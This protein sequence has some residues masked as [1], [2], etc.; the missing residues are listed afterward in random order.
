MIVLLIL[1]T[2]HILHRK[3]QRYWLA[4]QHQ[5]QPPFH[6]PTRDPLLGLD[7]LLWTQRAARSRTFL[8]QNE[9]RFARYGHTHQQRQLLTP[10]HE[11]TGPLLGQGILTTDGGSW[12]HTRALLRPTFA[13]TQIPDLSIFDSLMD[14]LLALIPTDGR[15][16]D[17]QKLFFCYS[18]DSA[19]EYLSGRCIHTLRKLQSPGAEHGEDAH[20]AGAF[21]HAQAAMQTRMRLGILRVFHRDARAKE[22]IRACHRFVGEVID[23]ALG[24]VE[25]D[26]E[27]LAER[28]RPVSLYQETIIE[29][30]TD[31]TR[32]CDELLHILLAMKYLRYCLHE[33]LRLH[34][35]MPIITRFANRD[36]VLPVGGGLR[37]LDPV[38]VIKGTMAIGDIYAMHR[39]GEI[40]GTDALGFRPERWEDLRPES[41]CLGQHFALT[42]AGYVTVCLAQKFSVLERRDC[43]PWQE[44]LTM[45]LSSNNG[46]WVSLRE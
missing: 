31:R 41:I 6:L 9:Q 20:V 25:E 15:P 37:G 10:I 28:D 43:R 42:E 8:V 36:T 33:S 29:Q 24:K 39:R 34:P 23:D 27:I 26:N 46:T 7:H 14:D 5:C 4:R 13:K 12:S 35:P 44:N 22:S 40:F 18:I 11:P 16:V 45:T 3:W 19:T 32:L 1:I 38:L 2:I 21:N 30:T 17:L